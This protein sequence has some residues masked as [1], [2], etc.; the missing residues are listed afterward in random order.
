[1]KSQTITVIKLSEQ[2]REEIATILARAIRQEL[3][4]A[5]AGMKASLPPVAR[6]R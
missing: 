2:Q 1:M 6:F 3:L 5:N 4:I